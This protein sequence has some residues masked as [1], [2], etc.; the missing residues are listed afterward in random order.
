[1]ALTTV[2][3]IKS[4]M[5]A[6]LFA[7]SAILLSSCREQ[8]KE[9]EGSLDAIMTEQSENLSIVVTENGRK[10]YR[11]STPLLEGYMLGR[12]PYREFRKGIKITTFQDDSMMTVNATLEA[13]YAIYY[14]N[15]K[16]WEAKGNVRVNKFDGTKLYTQ[17]L[18]WDSTT[19]RIYSNVDTKVVTESDTHFCEGFDSDEELVELKFRRWKG[20]MLME[21]DML[22]PKDS[23]SDENTLPIDDTTPVANGGEMK[24]RKAT[25]EESSK[26]NKGS[27]ASTGRL[28]VIGKSES[29]KFPSESSEQRPR[30]R[31]VSKPQNA[32]FVG[33]NKLENHPLKAKTIEPMEMNVSPAIRSSEKSDISNG[34][35]QTGELNLQNEEN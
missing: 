35:L 28:G 12:D 18:F 16:L 25:K 29:G 23:L 1:M 33:K 3:L 24:E 30:S 4:A 13:N 5:V 11:F 19:K 31:I 22:M 9:E 2:R 17:Q 14:E 7:G 32:Q 6:L 10:S 21:E 15:R 26:E 20:K 34:K 8:P 27:D